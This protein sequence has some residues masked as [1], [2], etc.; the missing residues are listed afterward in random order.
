MQERQVTVE[1]ESHPLEAPFLVIATQNPIDLEGTYA[2]PEAQ[3]DRFLMR[4]AVGY[5]GR[6][7]EREILSRRR[8]R[9]TEEA[10]IE[11]VAT[12]ADLLAMQTA[13]EDVH[14][15]VSIEEYIVDLARATRDDTRLAPGAAAHGSV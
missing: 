8:T 13:L 12:R 11:K 15:D 10:H 14:V 4:I 2:L 7:E 9:R 6:E 5:P 1:G 3:L